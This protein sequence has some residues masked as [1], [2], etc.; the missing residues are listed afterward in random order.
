MQIK[1]AFALIFSLLLTACADGTSPDG[2]NGDQQPVDNTYI[3]T[4]E[5]YTPVDAYDYVNYL[6]QT[7]GLT[8]VDKNLLLQDSANNHANYLMS[9]NITGHDET[10]GLA[11]FT[12]EQPADR[13]NYAGY[14]SRSVGEGI[15]TQSSYQA[16][17]DGLFSAIYHRFTLLDFAYDEIGISF[18][19]SGSSATNGILVHN[20]G[21]SLKNDLCSGNSF[22]GAGTYY[23]DVCANSSFRIEATQFDNADLTNENQ[24]PLLTVW[25]PANSVDIPPVFFDET[26]DP[27]PDYSVSGYP[28]SL[29]FNPASVSSVVINSIY[30]YQDASNNVITETRMLDQNSDPNARFS[31]LEFAMFPLQRLDWNT[32]YRVNIEYV[33]NGGSPVTKQWTFTTRKPADNILKISSG[34]SSFSIPANVATAVYIPPAGPTDR[35]TSLSYSYPQNVTF[36]SEFIDANTLLISVSG[37]P[38]QQVTIK[39]TSGDTTATRNLVATIQ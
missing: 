37:S 32:K 33:V 1:F 36:T 8:T 31:K 28:V 39:L 2:V 24:N 27:L 16:A 22:T 19:E 29:Q 26:P 20:M 12:G 13:A 9:N 3:N 30:L 17:I 34:T 5:V 18:I 21:N 11:G 7:A 23:Y 25:P 10:S 38:G 4:G 14:L 6:R 15:A 35:I